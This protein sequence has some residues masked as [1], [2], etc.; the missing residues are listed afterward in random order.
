[1][2]YTYIV[3]TL[4]LGSVLPS[5]IKTATVPLNFTRT[6]SEAT[7]NAPIGWFPLANT[8]LTTSGVC[9]PN[10]YGGDTFN[11][12]TACPTSITAQSGGFVDTDHNQIC[13]FGEG[14][15]DG[16]GNEV[17]CVDLTANPAWTPRTNPTIPSNCQAASNVTRGLCPG[18]TPAHNACI[19]SIPP[20]NPWPVSGVP[21]TDCLT[22]GGTNCA[23]NARHSYSNLGYMPT[24]GAFLHSGVGACQA[25]GSGITDTW[26]FNTTTNT[27]SSPSL[28]FLNT[29]GHN[30]MPVGN[31]GVRITAWDSSNNLMWL[32]TGS[33]TYSSQNGKQ[34]YL[35]TFDPST[36]TYNLRMVD[37]YVS[38]YMEGVVDP[39]DHYLFMFGSCAY[40]ACNDVGFIHY[41]VIR[42]DISN[43]AAPVRTNITAS[44]TG[45]G[46]L[47]SFNGAGPPAGTKPND[48]NIG[49][50]WDPVWNLI[51][52]WPNF[53]D[54]VY[55]FNPAAATVTTPFGSVPQ[56]T[57]LEVTSAVLGS[58]PPDSANVS[59]Q[60]HTSYGTYNR[61]GYLPALDEFVVVN[62]PN[63]NA[64]ALRL[65]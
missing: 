46:N 52:A 51:V 35:F 39:V 41:G 25:G 1:M 31:S 12:A 3:L 19:A 59:G 29:G 14:H 40:A 42:Y 55:L 50:A 20:Q 15:N 34:G 53:G 16:Y 4:L 23:P 54:S 21:G 47:Y 24:F 27:W 37:N 5:W 63:S 36:N 8:T 57:C 33:A 2:R 44:T 30:S 38:L 48:L 18:F 45:C 6:V 13:V 43:P 10:Y 65:R 26:I 60:P 49:L 58:G 9:P 61:F 17:M 22:T 56:N 28:T 32:H 62:S 11:F 64:Y 7:V